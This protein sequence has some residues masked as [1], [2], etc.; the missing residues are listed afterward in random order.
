MTFTL[1]I[2]IID[3]LFR[4]PIRYALPVVLFAG[5][6]FASLSSAD[7]FEATGVVFVDESSVIADLT[8]VSADGFSFL[9]AAEAAQEQLFGLIQTDS[10]MNDVLDEAGSAGVAPRDPVVVDAAREAISTST[11]SGS[12]LDVSA[13]TTSPESAQALA[14]A[15]LDAYIGWL[16]EADL[17]ETL[18]A[19]EFLAQQVALELDELQR[20]R[21][22]VDDFLVLNPDPLVGD[23]STQE[24]IDL[25]ILSDSVTAS[26]AKYDQAVQALESAE[27]LTSQAEIN[28]R[29]AFRVEDA[30]KLPTEPLSSIFD[31]ALRVALFA[32]MGTAMSAAALLISTVVDTNVRFPIEV[33]ERLGTEV[34]AFVPRAN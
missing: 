1:L 18:A 15:T 28:V 13:T 12:F 16:I 21:A 6:G 33:R 30:P 4:H 2:R 24:T 19:E 7:E 8:E 10:F 22:A 34:L 25:A 26:Q 23:R 14:T 29:S 20:A 31:A 3:N 17:T 5:I 9:S 11:S 27:L 32:I